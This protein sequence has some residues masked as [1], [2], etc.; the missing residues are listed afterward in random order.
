MHIALLCFL[1]KY[2]IGQNTLNKGKQLLFNW[3]FLNS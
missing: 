1:Y 3:L 2:K